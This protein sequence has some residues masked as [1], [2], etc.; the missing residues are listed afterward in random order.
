MWWDMGPWVLAGTR[1]V[2]VRLGGRWHLQRRPGSPTCFAPSCAA[3]SALARALLASRLRGCCGGLSGCSAG[4]R[5]HPNGWGAPHSRRLLCPRARFHTS[6][7][8]SPGGWAVVSSSE[9]AF[10]KPDAL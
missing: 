5:G 3:H 4:R 1:R 8:T 10:N 7:P 9:P 2:S 6:F